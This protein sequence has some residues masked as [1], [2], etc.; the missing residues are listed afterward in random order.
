M[1]GH[2]VEGTSRTMESVEK[3]N[4]E[5]SKKRSEMIKSR[6][7]KDGNQWSAYP[8]TEPASPKGIADKAK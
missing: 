7:P 4:K 6:I 5:L 3:K 1:L 2:R 8:Q